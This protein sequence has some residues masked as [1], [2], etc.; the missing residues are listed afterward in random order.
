MADRG[1]GSL[2]AEYAQGLAQVEEGRIRFE[3]Y[4]YGGR[5]EDSTT[6]CGAR[7]T[8][9]SEGRPFVQPGLN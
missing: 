7:V 8:A 2:K 6:N 5:N 3:I 4:E 1:L 9:G